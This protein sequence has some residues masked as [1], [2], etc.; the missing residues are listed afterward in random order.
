VIHETELDAVQVQPARVSTLIVLVVASAGTDALTGA[1]ANVQASPACV[2]V[3]VSP[4]MVIVP[5][6]EDVPGFAETLYVICPLP[7]PLVALVIVIQDAES[8]AVHAHP[9][10]AV[11]AMVPVAALE[12]SVALTGEST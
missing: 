1:I 3:N 2:M 5:F 10:P 4:P 12:P 9:L 11:T 7:L 6:R 8:E